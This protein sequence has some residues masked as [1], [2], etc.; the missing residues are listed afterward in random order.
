MYM[1]QTR[2]YIEF[3][4]IIQYN[5]VINIILVLYEPAWNGLYDMQI[6]F[7]YM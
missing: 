3:I 6:I 5:L 2:K 7:Y 4:D 1:C